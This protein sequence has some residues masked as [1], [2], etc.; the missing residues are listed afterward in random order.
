LSGHWGLMLA[1]FA[2]AV[3]GKLVGCGAA[4]LACGMDWARSARVGCGMISRGVVGL[5]VT[6]VGASTGMFDRP[7][8][9]VMVA[10]VLLTTLLTRVAL[11]GAFRLRFVQQ[12]VEGW[13]E[14]DPAAGE[15]A[16]APETAWAGG[17]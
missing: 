5:I 6:A 7:E 13:V 17:W 14:A 4:A 2:V 1:I 11:R 9:A 15:V 8:V 3:I 12:G 10:V 16:R